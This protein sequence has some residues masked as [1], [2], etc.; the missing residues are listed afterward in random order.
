MA[1]LGRRACTP[2]LSGPNLLDAGQDTLQGLDLGLQGLDLSPQGIF[3]QVASAVSLG[4]LWAETSQ[5][6]RQTQTDT[7]IQLPLHSPTNQSLDVQLEGRNGSL[8]TLALLHE[9]VRQPHLLREPG[10]GGALRI[11]PLPE[12]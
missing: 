1:L 7:A 6:G 11:T 9:L 4:F 10:G 5:P 3:C 8:P 2:G 12:T